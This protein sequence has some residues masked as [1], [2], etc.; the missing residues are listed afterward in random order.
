MRLGAAT[1]PPVGEEV[2]GDSLL[3]LRREFGN[4]LYRDVFTHRLIE[5]EK[6]KEKHV[7]PLASIFGQMP[8]AL[9]EGVERQEG[10]EARAGAIFADELLESSRAPLTGR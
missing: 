2:W 6:R 9:L 5:I 7:L 10:A 3:V 4:A 1:R 8:V